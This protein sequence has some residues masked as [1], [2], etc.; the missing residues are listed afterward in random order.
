MA[1]KQQVD[2]LT[3]KV[4]DTVEVITDEKYSAELRHGFYYYCYPT[5][6]TCEKARPVKMQVIAGE[7]I[8]SKCYLIVRVHSQNVHAVHHHLGGCG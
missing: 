4:D 5:I 3:V 6:G 8:Q 1:D 2:E 7:T